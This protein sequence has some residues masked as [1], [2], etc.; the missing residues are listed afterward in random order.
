MIP[1]TTNGTQWLFLQLYK[2]NLVYRKETLVNWCPNDKTVLANEQVIDGKC[3][4]CGH[5]VVQ[6]EMLQWNVKITD[7]ADRL[8]D[9]LDNWI[10]RSPSKKRSATGSAGAKRRDRFLSGLR[11]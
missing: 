5:E 4:R 10:G 11:R 7:Y 1:R 3:E 8:I 6:K 2:S 9:D